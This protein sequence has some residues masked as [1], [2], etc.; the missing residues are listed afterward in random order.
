MDIVDSIL[1]R[2]QSDMRHDQSVV[3]ANDCTDVISTPV[4]GVSLAS[5]ITL[6]ILFWK[7]FPH[8]SPLGVVAAAL[9]L[10]FRVA[11]LAS[12]SRA[13]SKVVVRVLVSRVLVSRVAV[14]VLVS[15]VVVL[16]RVLVSSVVVLVLVIAVVPPA[17]RGV[18][19][20]ATQHLSGGQ[21]TEKKLLSS[22]IG[23]RIN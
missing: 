13:A 11:V 22:Q 14:L 16:V 8:G 20:A 9:V 1:L 5:S 15:R 3:A 7:S 2:T 19:G 12:V 10:V 21:R 17:Q 6:L 18:S 23:K 4:D